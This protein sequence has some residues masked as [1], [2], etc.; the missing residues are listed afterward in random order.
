VLEFGHRGWLLDESFVF[1]DREFDSLWV[2]ATGVCIQGKFKGEQ[3][4][5]I[6]ITHTTWKEWRTLH[7]ESLVL[8]KPSYQVERYRRDAYERLYAERGTQFGLGVFVA[9][10]QKLYPLEKLKTTPIVT[11]KIGDTPVLVVFHPP[12]KTAVAFD[13][14]ID[15]RMVEFELVEVTEFDVILRDSNDN[16]FWSGLTGRAQTSDDT[17]PR[18]R[19]LRTTQFVTGNWLKH[20]SDGLIYDP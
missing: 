4:A 5:T 3:L 1:F 13:P 19:Q 18:L 20:F 2:Q 10:Q 16:T 9:G 17:R 12:S 8:A 15:D 6:P 14:M 7:P 11:D